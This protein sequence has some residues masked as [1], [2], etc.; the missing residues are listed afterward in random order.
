MSDWPRVLVVG[1]SPGLAG[2]AV[3][4]GRAALEAAYVAH[5]VFGAVG[6]VDFNQ[7]PV[8]IRA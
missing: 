3:L 5:Q 8:I 1:G 2:A 7:G 4:T 6:V